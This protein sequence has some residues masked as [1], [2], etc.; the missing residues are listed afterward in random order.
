M[1]NKQQARHTNNQNKNQSRTTT[2]NR[3]K[4]GSDDCLQQ[5][6]RD[7]LHGIIDL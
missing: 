7:K 5:N 4:S 1:K 2:Q 6:A 3:K